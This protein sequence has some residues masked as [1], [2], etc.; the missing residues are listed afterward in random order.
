MIDTKNEYALNYALIASDLDGTL[1]RS[2]K[3]VGETTRKAIEE[4]LKAGG[5]FCICSGRML[6]SVA[7]VAKDLGL[8]GVVAS[9]A[10]ALVTDLASGKTLY[11]DSLSAFDAATIASFIEK[12]GVHLQY[13]VGNKYYVN[14]EGEA[15]TRYEK[16][17]RVQAERVLDT[18]L[19]KRIE[20][21]GER[22]NKLLVIVEDESRH[23]ELLNKYVERFGTQFWVTRSTTRYIEILSKTCNKGVALKILADYYKIPMERTLAVGDQLNDEEMLHAAGLG[24]CVANGNEEM[25]RRVRVYDASNEED[26]VGKIIYDF[27]FENG[28]KK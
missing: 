2:D 16:S 9:Y 17:C 6:P 7:L 3:S 1:L 26:A 12:D 13:Y 20:E 19:S 5:K 14:R 18:P 21:R 10:G 25:K 28:R 22:V 23:A 15:L 27:G 24:L 11:E 8:E 4:Y